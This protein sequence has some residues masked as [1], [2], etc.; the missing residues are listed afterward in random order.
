[1]ANDMDYDSQDFQQTISNLRR[2]QKALNQVEQNGTAE[3][4]TRPD[5]ATMLALAEEIFGQTYFLDK[6]MKQNFIAEPSLAVGAHTELWSSDSK[7][8]AKAQTT[9]FGLT[10][11]LTKLLFGPHG[12]LHEYVSSNWEY[13]ALYTVLEFNILE[14]IPIDGQAHVS[15]LAAQSGLPENK[16]LR[17]LR[18]ISCEKILEEVSEQVFRHT[19]IS[20]ELVKDKKFKAFIGFQYVSSARLS[21]AKH[22]ILSF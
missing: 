2:Q 12:F 21:S 14:G 22:Q 16:L 9:I 1:M 19:A 18:L 10:K 11:Q 17:I 4:T 5:S 3:M 6:Y 7:E 8:I 15:E 13:G 20:E